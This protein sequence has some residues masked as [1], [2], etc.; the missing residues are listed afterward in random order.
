[1][2]GSCRSY[3]DKAKGQ[4]HPSW[5]VDSKRIATK[6]KNASEAL[7]PSRAIWKSNPTKVCPRCNHTIDNSDIVQEW[8]GLPKGV[9]FDPSDQE[10]IS[11]LLAKVKTGD[12]IPHPFINEF[13]PTV[14][15]EEGICYAHPQKLPGVKKDGS[16][17]HFF[18]RTFKAYNTGTRK[19][20][21]I[22]T[23]GN[24][25]VRWHKTGK[26]KPVIVDG[27]HLGCKKIMVLYMSTMKGEK[28]EKTNWVMHQYHLGTGEDEKDGEYVVSKIFYQQQQEQ[29]KAGDRKG[30]DFVDAES[31]HSPGIQSVSSPQIADKQENFDMLEPEPS[32]AHQLSVN[33]G[34]EEHQV[35][36]ED[37]KFE[38]V[39]QVDHPT[40]ATKWWESESQYL[41]NSQQ[42]AEN[43]A[44]CEEFL[45]SQSSCADETAKKST[46]CLSDYVHIGAEALKKDLEE[47][48]TLEAAGHPNIEHD[49][50][51]DLRLSQ[52][53]FGSQDSFSWAFNKVAD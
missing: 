32:L 7:D 44:I 29:T 30:P 1:M 40:G 18:H 42:L 15:E 52:L 24:G 53:E 51:P 5:L 48:Q 28:P 19:R 46:H 41:L 11:H 3:S 2:S 9:K 17:S 35:L 38:Q 27:R 34:D 8:P 43:I 6:I 13:I 37:N 22:S 36:L 21:K 47:C 50:P 45:Q 49:T 4:N 16:A 26:T 23:Y 25:D 12:A 14:E 10:L 33:S 39:E 20:R 31:D